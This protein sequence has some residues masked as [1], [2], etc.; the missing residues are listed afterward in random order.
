MLA[1]LAKLLA[2]IITVATL[3]I[4]LL[5][6]VYGPT[7]AR[8]TVGLGTPAIIGL[9]VVLSANWVSGEGSRADE[10]WGRRG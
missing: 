5:A 10:R 9:V 8:W 7:W 3:F 2:I 1:K 6:F 4:L